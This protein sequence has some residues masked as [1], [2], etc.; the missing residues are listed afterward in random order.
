MSAN[1]FAAIAQILAHT[2]IWVWA[3]LVLLIWRGLS[4]AT[5]REVSARKLVILPVVILY[6][7]LSGMATTA[8][9]FA[10]A[11]AVAL[12][13]ALGIVAGF[14][15]F[16]RTGAYQVVPGIVRLQGEW[17]TMVII[18]SIFALHYL[19]GVLT[20]TDPAL[21]ANPAYQIGMGGLSAFL[22]TMTITTALLRIRLAYLPY[23]AAE[24]FR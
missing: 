4:A 2:P 5:D 17:T 7:A 19:N 15:R 6:L 11:G 24:D 23:D 13:I 22:S 20:A 12:G 16:S 3:V 18:L 14:A 1:P 21:V 10:G 8:Q 9:T